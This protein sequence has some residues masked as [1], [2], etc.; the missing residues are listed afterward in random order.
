MRTGLKISET[1]I[2]STEVKKGRKSS[3]SYVSTREV[4]PC[5]K[6]RWEVDLTMADV[7]IRSSHFWYHGLLSFKATRE[8][9]TPGEGPKFHML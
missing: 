2:I 3:R 6:H 1:M 8:W 5:L 7:Q 9:A 4:P